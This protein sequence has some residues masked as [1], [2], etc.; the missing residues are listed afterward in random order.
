MSGFEGIVGHERPLGVLK[1]A[2]TSG[3]AHH[4]YL[5]AGPDGVGK[6]R[7]AL[8]F[9]Q[10]LNCPEAIS[11]GGSPC[12][13]CRSC[14]KIQ[15]GL[16]PDVV[17]VE[18]DR[19][20]TRW[21]LKIE[22]VREIT[23]QVHFKPYEG[24]RRVILIDDIHTV[25]IEGAN[26]FLKTLE[27]PTGDTLFVLL[28][29][30]PRRLLST[31]RSRCQ[32]L[33]FAPLTA[34]HL[35]T[36]LLQHAI[37]PQLAELAAHFAEGSVARALA[38]VA[39]GALDKRRAVIEG[40]LGLEEADTLDLFKLA[41]EL[42]AGQPEEIRDRLDFLLLFLR[43]VALTRAGAD[44][45]RIVNRDLRKAVERTAARWTTHQAT[46]AI[47]SIHDVQ[48]ALQA[49]VDPRLLMEDLLLQIAEVSA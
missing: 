41:E 16:H 21:T 48:R 5:F 24:L 8:A 4:A 2:V 9:A 13:A 29:D 12:G 49:Y 6:R 39:D 20:K 38:L 32:L 36:V 34:A 46:R 47:T 31:I 14:A 40:V 17:S 18:P 30:Q 43:D 27:E 42:A 3:R 25:T 35:Q 7:A 44:P 26:A 23:R 33:R 11:R 28:T 1:S 22:A 45:E 10:A 15:A 37:E 19:T